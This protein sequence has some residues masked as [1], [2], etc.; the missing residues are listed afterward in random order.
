MAIDSES[1]RQPR[2]KS[3]RAV[4]ATIGNGLLVPGRWLHARLPK[5]LFPRSLLIVV[6]PLVI[7]Q[8]VVAYVFLQRH[9]E[10]V[11]QRLS[12]ATTRDIAALIGIL[13]AYPQDPGYKT[14]REIAMRDLDLSVQVLPPTPLPPPADKPLFSLLDRTL[15]RLI[16]TQIQRPF[17]IDTVGRSDYVEIRIDLGDKV[18]RI[19]ARRSQTYASNAHIFLVWMVGASL[20]L[21][22]IAVLFLRNQI[23][24][25]QTLAEAAERFGRGQPVENFR[26]RGALEVRQAALA[27][28]EMRRRIERQ[29]EQRTT[30]L[31]GVSHDLR[32]ILT[33]FRLEL[34]MLGDDEEI[35]ALKQDVDVMNAML[36]AYLAF[37]RGDGDEQASLVDLTAMLDYIEDEAVARGAVV[38]STFEGEPM[39]SVKPMAF[40]RL[41]FNVV[42]NAARY[43]KTIEIFGR[44]ADG[45]ITVI[46]DD[47]GPGIPE[48]QREAVFRPFFR[49]DSARNQDQT[50]T[51]L[52]LTIARDAARGHGGDV[53]L[54]DSP[55]GGLRVR[56]RVPG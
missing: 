2:S 39:V 12:E 43:G 8:S 36:E 44:H 22:G 42:L 50:G 9:W 47:D 5:R 54:G 49:L 53:V 45:W 37:A 21:I 35:E 1:E 55:L 6:L 28:M 56:V 30:M 41:L 29:L 31:A 51:G 52:G 40:G 18:L 14:F 15:S 32:T 4:L 3:V 38:R 33:R 13:E 23:R 7:L 34:A 16:S 24:P 25:I 48:D 10:L 46:V 17:W 20:V 26:P 11:T 19:F 27:F